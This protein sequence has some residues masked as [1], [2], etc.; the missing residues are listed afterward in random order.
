MGCRDLMS[1]ADYMRCGDFIG[2]GD[3]TR[4]GDS[5]RC[6]DSMRGGDVVDSR[7]HMG[8]HWSMRVFTR[9]L[10]AIRTRGSAPRRIGAAMTNSAARLMA[11][12]LHS[13]GAAALGWNNK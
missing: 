7:D 13:S 8:C 2:C 10:S 11:M 12:P 1:C 9:V 3:S 5:V 6:G 4:C